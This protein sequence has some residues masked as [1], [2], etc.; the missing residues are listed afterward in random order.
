MNNANNKNNNIWV[1]LGFR[2]LM[3]PD[4]NKDIQCHVIPSFF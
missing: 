2:G 1:G 4:L 3:T